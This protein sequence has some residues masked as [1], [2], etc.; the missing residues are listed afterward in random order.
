MAQKNTPNHVL[1]LILSLVT[2][3]LWLPIWLLISAGGLGGW[4]CTQCGHKV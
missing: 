2:F 3:G 1:H 4:R